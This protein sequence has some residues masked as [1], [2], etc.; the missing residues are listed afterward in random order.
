MSVVTGYGRPESLDEL[1]SAVDAAAPDVRVCAGCTD[2]LPQANGGRLHAA[3]WLDLRRVPELSVFDVEGEEIRLGCCVTH[4]QVATSSELRK[5]APALAAACGAVGSRQI[6]ALGTLGGNAAN[7]SPCADSTLALAAL[8]A[9]AVLRSKSGSREVPVDGLAIGPGET[10]LEMGEIIEAFVI[11]APAGQRSVHLKLGPRRAHA[12]AKVSV[13]ASAAVDGG[14]LE[15]LR[16]YLGA[17]APTIIRATE[18]EKAVEGERP[19]DTS[20]AELAAAVERAVRPIDDV[21]STA[22]YRRRT[23]GVLAR[24]A[25]RAL[26]D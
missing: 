9:S 2:L 21:R 15:G 16:L 24:R 1:W 25:V 17:V 4:H 12:V 11:P 7:A 19:S 8:D 6:R 22:R 14:R 23:S 18:A 3:T 10:V 26:L 20:L 13:A 5:R